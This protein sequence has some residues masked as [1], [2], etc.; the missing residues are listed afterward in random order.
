MLEMYETWQGYKIRKRIGNHWLY[1]G[2]YYGG[3]YSWVVD[4]THAKQFSKA[5]AEKHMKRIGGMMI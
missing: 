4:Y 3:E 2:G 5:T 1:V